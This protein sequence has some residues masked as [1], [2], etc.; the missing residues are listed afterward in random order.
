MNKQD[1]IYQ[2]ARQRRIIARMTEA[3]EAVQ[4]HVAPIIETLPPERA[5]DK[6]LAKVEAALLLRGG[7]GE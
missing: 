1:L 7:S 3:L 2:V 6:A 4:D 5:A